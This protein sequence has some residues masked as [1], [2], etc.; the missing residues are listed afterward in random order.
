MDFNTA[1]I[2]NEIMIKFKLK[3]TILKLDSEKITFKTLFRSIC[4]D[5]E[6]Y[7]FHDQLLLA[8]CKRAIDVIDTICYSTRKYNLNTIYPLLRLQIDSCLV[9]QAAL[10]HKDSNVFFTDLLNRE[11]QI[12]NYKIPTTG[13]KMSE[14]KLATLISTEFPG[15]FEM[16]EYCCDFVHFT[17]LS[18]RLPIRKVDF[19]TFTVNDDVGNKED[20]FRIQLCLND[21]YQID[22]ILVNLI[23]QCRKEFI[24]YKNIEQ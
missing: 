1:F 3:E 12:R 19:L 4:D 9:L 8:V 22:K 7:N 16:Y 15:F 17:S 14:R 5:C 6:A 23:N 2:Y 11:F 24:P 20:K 18:L 10:L 21:L 13:E